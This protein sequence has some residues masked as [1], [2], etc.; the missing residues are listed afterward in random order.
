MESFQKNDTSAP[1]RSGH[2]CVASLCRETWQH[3]AFVFFFFFFFCHQSHS[4]KLLERFTG[5]RMN[6]E[7]CLFFLNLINLCSVLPRCINTNATS[8]HLCSPSLFPPCVLQRC[9]SADTCNV[10]REVHRSKR[11]WKEISVMCIQWKLINV[12]LTQCNSP[13]AQ[14]K[15]ST[16][17][18]RWQFLYSWPFH[19]RA[20]LPVSILQK[21]TKSGWVEE[22]ECLQGYISES[23]SAQWPRLI[24][25]VYLWKIQL[26]HP[27]AC[28]DSDLVV[29]VSIHR[30]WH[31]ASLHSTGHVEGGSASLS[32]ALSR[33]ALC[34]ILTNSAKACMHQWL[35]A[36]LPEG[37][38]QWKWKGPHHDT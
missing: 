23:A 26:I 35:W 32:A 7:L 27:H 14:A 1:K 29:C 34:R 12:W 38:L 22:N 25:T 3:T 9:L 6:V 2:V 19:C 16:K 13:P 15:A 10:L 36:L 11:S 31:V 30:P 28:F 20:P 21:A 33:G 5:V 17:P 24:N 37:L 4:I 8:A 18:Q